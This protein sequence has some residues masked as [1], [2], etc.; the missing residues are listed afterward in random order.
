MDEPSDRGAKT[1]RLSNRTI[2]V[3]ISAA[4]VVPNLLLAARLQAAPAVLVVAGCVGVFLLIVFAPMPKPRGVLGSPIA[5]PRLVSCLVFAWALL[6]LGGETH[7]FYANPDWLVRDTVL[8][9]LA[10]TPSLPTYVNHGIK[11]FLRAPLGMYMTPALAGGSFGLLAAHVALLVQNALILGAILYLFLEMGFGWRH[12]SVLVLFGGLS[13]LARILVLIN[14]GRVVLFSIDRPWDEWHPFLQ[15]TSSVTQFFWVPNHAL[16]GWWVAALLLL[17]IDGEIDAAVIGVSIAALQLWSPLAILPAVPC[18]LVIFSGRL[19]STLLSSRTWMGLA[20]AAAFIP[21]TVYLTLAAGSI[22]HGPAV[23]KSTFPSHLFYY[24][25]FIVIELAAAM[26][27]ALERPRLSPKL[28]SLFWTSFVILLVL[29]W[30][31]FGPSNDLVMRASIPPLVIVAFCLGDVLCG[32]RRPRGLASL[33]GWAI[34][35]VGA[36]PAVVE[37]ARAL[38]T[39]SYPISNCSL[40][41]AVRGTKGVPTHYVVPSDQAPVWL[42]PHPST[43]PVETVTRSCWPLLTWPGQIITAVPGPAR[44]VTRPAER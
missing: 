17:S 7:L 32:P 2:L 33:V 30:F 21:I 44:V 36:A 23:P 6:L 16:P 42:L 3:L 10:K 5:W 11:Y 43:W 1:P 29:P 9:D 18:A 19:R 22:S 24:D 13:A 12:L 4:F 14:G 39:P 27:V 28:H 40:M 25:V 31:S 15:Y 26:F 41:E 34:V 37:V 20:V 35:T 8:A 38:S